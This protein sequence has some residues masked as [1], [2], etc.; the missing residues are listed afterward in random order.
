MQG[1]GQL[2]LAHTSQR[3]GAICRPEALWLGELELSEQMEGH[4]LDAGNL[5]H[6]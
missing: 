5:S 6:S 4:N 2:K 3:R 1:H